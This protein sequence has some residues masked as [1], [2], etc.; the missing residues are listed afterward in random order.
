ML[1]K[2]IPFIR[3]ILPVC[4]GIICGLYFKPGNLFFIIGGLSVL[5]LFLVSLLYNRRIANTCFGFT[6][7]ITLFFTGLYL[8][9]REINSLSGL[10]NEEKVYCGILCDYPEEKEN[11]YLMKIKMTVSFDDKCRKETIRGS[12]LI[13]C[14]K[15]SF[16][17]LYEPGDRMVIRCTPL[18][19]KARGNP[20]E[21]NYILYMENHATKYYSF[22]NTGNI[23]MSVPP[24]RRKMKYK[25][26]IIRHKIIE[27]FR[28]EGIT[29]ER[30]ALVAAITLG[31]KNMLE[32][33]QKLIFMKA[34][35]MHIMAVSGLHAMIMSLFVF[36]ILF[37]LK[38]KFMI[39]RILITI[40]V[41]WLFAYVTGLTSSVLRATLMYTFLQGGKLIKRPANPINSVLASAFVLIMIRASVIF[42]AGFLLSYSA[43]IFIINFYG[44]FYGKLRFRHRLPD[45]IW[46][47]TAVTVIA[48]AGTLP[49]TIT[50]FNR[51]PV[52]FIL[53]NIIIVPLASLE[54]V[55][56]FLIPLLSFLPLLPDL[57]A[58][59]LNKLTGLTESLTAT[60][61]SLPFSTIENTGMT[62]IECILLSLTIFL[63]LQYLLKRNS[64]SILF[65]LSCILALST[66]LTVKH[67]VLS[68]T[69][70]IIV[71]NNTGPSE[72]GIR[73]GKSLYIYSD[74]NGISNEAKKH[75]SVLGLRLKQC[76]IPLQPVNL[77]LENERIFIL[78]DPVNKIINRLSSDI[79]IIK[80]KAAPGVSIETSGKPETLVLVNESPRRRATRNIIAG[81]K[82]DSLHIIRDD[83]AYI[84]KLQP[85]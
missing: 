28:K 69:N 2:E 78:T 72:I 80:G 63:T 66:A 75:S 7:I 23:L 9:T 5:I 61:S 51:F 47:M 1:Y 25:A 77:C 50:L 36:K 10:N 21:F 82:A 53:S 27:I 49:L 16:N 37:F 83:G 73:A 84:R 32:P 40:L 65:P 22:I 68:A 55:T 4:L 60:V 45:I 30:L 76:D 56:G 44:D 54:I 81:I 26:L 14:S 52:W 58:G 29:G 74:G 46:Q 6:Y 31:Q 8:Y 12:L 20:C 33:G 15:E 67:F 18:E 48:Q 64:V 3:I 11:S 85:H 38:K 17:P 70:E 62:G 35:V 57:L 13:Y 59:L 39:I 24:E 79:V 34:G 71:Y 43:V 19:I 41:L 42:D